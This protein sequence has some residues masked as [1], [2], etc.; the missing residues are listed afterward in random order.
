LTALA[1]ALAL[2]A[3]QAPTNGPGALSGVPAWYHAWRI[4]SSENLHV[5]ARP[6]AFIDNEA[7]GGLEIGAGFTVQ[8]TARVF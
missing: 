5:G 4:Y 6:A 7:N 3:S 1:F 2:S 8:I